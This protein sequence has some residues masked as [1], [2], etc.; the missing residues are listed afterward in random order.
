MGGRVNAALT[1]FNNGLVSPE[2]EART[3]LQVAAY[4]CRQLKNASVEVAGG[5]HR[6]GGSVYVPSKSAVTQNEGWSSWGELDFTSYS[7]TF[8]QNVQYNSSIQK[9]VGYYLGNGGTN[10][11]FSRIYYLSDDGIGWSQYTFAPA[12][13][14]NYDFMRMEVASDGT[15]F[16]YAHYLES[17]VAYYTVF[18]SSDGL[19]WTKCYPTDIRLGNKYYW[20]LQNG[21]CLYCPVD[22]SQNYVAY[23]KYYY[24]TSTDRTTASNWTEVE[25]STLATSLGITS[26]FTSYTLRPYNIRQCGQ[27]IIWPVMI[28]GNT[29]TATNVTRVYFLKS[30]DGITWNSYTQADSTFERLSALTVMFGQYGKYVNGKYFAYNN[31]YYE[32]YV[33]SDLETWTRVTSYNPWQTPPYITWVKADN[34][35]CLYMPSERN[36]RAAHYLTSTDGSTWTEDTESTIFTVKVEGD[37]LIGIDG[38]NNN[39]YKTYLGESTEVSGTKALLIPF[40]VNRNI[41]YI[42]EFGDYY[43]RFYRKHAQ[44]LDPNTGYGIALETPYSLDEL[45][46]TTTGKRKLG[47]IQSADVM[48]LFHEN[49]PVQKLSRLSDTSWTLAAASFKCGPWE[50]MNTDKE[51]TLTASATTGTITLTASKSTFSASDVGRYVR[52]YASNTNTRYWYSGETSI[53]TST[54]Y[55]SDGKFYQA[56]S[57]GTAG[58]VTPT[59]TE[60]SASDGNLIWTY[61]HSGYGT[62]KITAFTSATS[63]T[64]QVEETLPNIAVTTAQYRW[65]LSIAEY[66]KCG[67]FY[68]ERLVLGINS[69]SG[70]VVGFSQSGDYENFDDVEF[71]EVKANCG[72]KLLISGDLSKIEWLSASGGSLYVGTVGGVTEVKPQSTSS[73]FGPENISYDKITNI[74]S[75]SL[76]PILIGGSNLY[77]GGAGKSIHDLIYLNDNDMYDPQEVSQ[78]A[79]TWLKKGIV[80][81]AL[82]YD[83]DRIVW[84]VMQ[85]GTIM[86]LTYNNIQQVKAFHKHTTSG[87]FISVASIPSP[88]G[89]TDELWAVIERTLNGETTYCVEYFRDGLPIDIPSNY[90]EEQIQ[91][92]LLKYAY[93]VDCGTQIT[94]DEPTAT[95][96][97]LDWLEGKEVSILADGVPLQEQTVEN[98]QVTLDRPATVV[99]IG[100]PY[101]TIFEPLP[102]NVDAQNGTGNARAQRINKIV[103]RLLNSGGFHYG[104]NKKMDYAELR[105]SNET[106]AVVS[107]KSGDIKLNW[108]GDN[109]TND[110]FDNEIPNATGARMVFKQT[111]PLPLRILGIYPQ[112][113]VTND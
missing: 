91:E 69:S 20:A 35:F 64:A 43:V 97:D 48:Y 3:D 95:I 100:L 39:Y 11:N 2:I 83:P 27:Q 60:G 113:E 28:T 54:D 37:F 10:Q 36:T 71:G 38:T 74:S 47:Y 51:A 66:P 46:D 73:A 50:N 58:N 21:T 86:G 57:S 103:V 61:K 53:T 72:M 18:Y 76:Q 104:D 45:F 5:V 82:Q 111:K 89:Q 92:Y 52:I 41:A 98:G 65:Q 110:I 108:P 22:T 101:E 26:D 32:Q 31:S 19:T 59:H 63:V 99:S 102:V 55:K 112:L 109:T 79:K 16:A 87:K 25:A 77:I 67:T 56:S 81:W 44:I 15:I 105:K 62:A 9:F 29:S 4:S 23:P 85:D 17:N 14:H 70:P 107:L 24:C 94:F 34:V 80:D 33:S 12:T 68:K 88:D 1:Q 7:A 42:L 8:W 78:L 90:T 75:N 13:D 84:C 106:G 49:H 40:V 30:S 96:T 6:R 93:F